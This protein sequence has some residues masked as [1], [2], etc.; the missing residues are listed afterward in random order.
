MLQK[1][2]FISL[3]IFLGEIMAQIEDTTTYNSPPN[4]TE[5][6]F[7]MILPQNVLV[8][9]NRNLGSSDSIKTYYVNKRNIPSVNV[10][11]DLDGFLG[12]NIPDT[13]DYSGQKVILWQDKEVIKRDDICSDTGSNGICDTLA[14]HFYKQFIA[15]PISNYLNTTTNPSTGNYLKDEIHYIVLCKGIPLKINAADRYWNRANYNVS[16]DGLLCLLKT[17]NN[18]NPS[19]MKLYPIPPNYWYN[20]T[21]SNSY[22]GVDLN[23]NFNHR[24]KANHYTLQ[25]RL[26]DGTQSEFKIAAL[27]SRLDGRNTQEV[28]AMIDKS[29]D[30]D[31]SGNGTWILDGHEYY[32]WETD[33]YW[34]YNNYNNNTITAAAN[35]LKSYNF[36]VNSDS[37]SRQPILSNSNNSVIGY[38]SWGRHSGLPLG[39]MTDS[40]DFSFLNGSVYNTIESHNA[41]T[42]QP[43][44]RIDEQSL[45]SE[46]MQIEGTSGVGH[47]WEPRLGPNNDPYY[48]F[49]AYAMG[50]NV[51]EAAY[52]GVQ[53]LGWQNTVFGDPLTTIAWGKQ[54]LT[55]NLT[56]SDTNLVTGKLTVPLGKTLTIDSTAVL[57]FRHTGSIEVNGALV[58]QPGAKLNFYNGNKLAINNVFTANGTSGKKITF[59]FISPNATT[60]NGI[61]INSGATVSLSYAVIKNAY[62]GI[63]LNDSDPLINY[64][65]FYNN[66]AGI[67]AYYSDYQLTQYTGT[68]IH[69]S[70]FYQNTRGISLAESSPLITT[71]EFVSNTYGI[72]CLE[73][74]AYLGEYLEP[75]VNNFDANDHAFFARY[76]YPTL[77]SCQ[78]C[79][80]G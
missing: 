55:A 27:V 4:Q 73:S 21:I 20:S 69:N 52:Q 41:Y 30:V 75:G 38:L 66:F 65:E 40:L 56:L 62:N 12:L 15:D 80:V 3:L 57:S 46:F 68:R 36:N 19:I 33:Y 7:N 2:L 76:S 23:F 77:V 5:S 61:E 18:S 37:T 31:K 39:F 64:C 74:D 10:I 34:Q 48:F 9:Y 63:F 32:Y 11:R 58:I 13:A 71:N 49:P 25:K 72:Y 29:F 47:T 14:W 28:I 17:N 54:T 60:S 43:V 1:I 50:Y 70:Y 8:V 22:R 26:N 59:D 67:Y 35:K 78:L 79:K 16:L 6:N 24:F 51:V 45:L 53:Y 44:Y 42:T